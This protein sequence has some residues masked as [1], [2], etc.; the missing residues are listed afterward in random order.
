MLSERKAS[1]KTALGIHCLVKK[2][3]RKVDSFNSYELLKWRGAQLRKI[4]GPGSMFTV[5][6]VDIWEDWT[7]FPNKLSSQINFLDVDDHVFSI[8]WLFHPDLGQNPGILLHQGMYL[9]G[10]LTWGQ[11]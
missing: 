6:Y 3:G 2:A 4:W 8:K 10:I 5:K 1:K 9:S 7:F 11:N